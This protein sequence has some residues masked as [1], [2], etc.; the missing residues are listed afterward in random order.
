MT[1]K[2]DDTRHMI[3]IDPL[4]TAEF[5]ARIEQQVRDE[6]GIDQEDLLALCQLAASLLMSL[7]R[8]IIEATVVAAGETVN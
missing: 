1:D 4:E 5:I 8:G 2:A 6:E 3:S 7:E